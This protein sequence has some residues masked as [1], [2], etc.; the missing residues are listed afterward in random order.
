MSWI[1]HAYLSS[2]SQ[3][4]YPLFLNSTITANLSLN[5]FLSNVHTRTHA[6]IAIGVIQHILTVLLHRFKSVLSYL[7]GYAA[8]ASRA[9]L[10][11]V[12]SRIFQ[13]THARHRLMSKHIHGHRRRSPY[14]FSWSMYHAFDNFTYNSQQRRSKSSIHEKMVLRM[15]RIEFTHDLQLSTWYYECAV[16]N[17]SIFVSVLLHATNVLLQS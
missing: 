14:S 7:C 5:K 12:G 13:H 8:S 3:P 6:H 15:R 10:D 17:V 9:V 2:L 1:S 16:T 4:A 11:N